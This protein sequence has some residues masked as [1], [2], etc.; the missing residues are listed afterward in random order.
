M[1]AASVTSLLA[2][3]AATAAFQ[4]GGWTYYSAADGVEVYYSVRINS[5]EARVAW[6]CVNTTGTARSCSIGAGR[7][8]VYRCLN[9]SSQVGVTEALGERARVRAYNEYV[10]PSDGACRGLGASTVD[11]SAQ[12]SIES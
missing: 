10:F 2:A 3:F 4:S 11:P 6:K 5:D 9:G 8:K 1:I 7:N 12:I